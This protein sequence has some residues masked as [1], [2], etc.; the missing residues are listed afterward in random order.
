VNLYLILPYILL[1]R[2]CAACHPEVRKVTQ[3]SLSMLRLM[4][5]FHGNKDLKY[6]ADLFGYF[7]KTP[8]AGDSE[9]TYRLLA[10]QELS[11]EKWLEGKRKV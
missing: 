4:V 9:D 5:F 3:M 2:Y 10:A 11:I 7:E 6:V 1:E 8:E